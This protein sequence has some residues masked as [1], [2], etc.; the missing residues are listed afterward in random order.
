MSADYLLEHNPTPTDQEIREGIRG[1]I[2]RCTGY[3]QIWE[4]IEQAARRM[5]EE[6]KA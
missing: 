4:A 1:N 6:A 5:R 2:C 3:Q